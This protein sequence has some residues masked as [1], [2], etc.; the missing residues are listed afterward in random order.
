[1]AGQ[2]LSLPVT[3]HW[4]VHPVDADNTAVVFKAGQYTNGAILPNEALSLLVGRILNSAI[5]HAQTQTPH[6]EDGEQINNIPVPVVGIAVTP[7]REQTEAIASVWEPNADL[8]LERSDASRRVRVGAL[9]AVTRR[10][11]DAALKRRERPP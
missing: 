5:T 7:G 8:F 3:P 10:I 9:R 6:C 1:M 4:Q 11:A 2:G